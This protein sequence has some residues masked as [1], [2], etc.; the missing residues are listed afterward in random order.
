M[1]LVLPRIPTKTSKQ[2]TSKIEHYGWDTPLRVGQVPLWGLHHRVCCWISISIAFLCVDEGSIFYGIWMLNYISSLSKK[3][4]HYGW[5]RFVTWGVAIN[6]KLWLVR[7]RHFVKSVWFLEE[8]M[9]RR[10]KICM[11]LFHIDKGNYLKIEA[12]RVGHRNGSFWHTHNSYC[13]IHNPKQNNVWAVQ[14]ERWSDQWHNLSSIFPKTDFYRR[15][16]VVETGNPG[17]AL[18]HP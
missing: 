6:F 14:E 8:D 5:D 11:R 16:L 3:L 17:S 10:T 12:L 7:D 18:S 4:K 9:S 15:N 1:S 2:Q 13:R